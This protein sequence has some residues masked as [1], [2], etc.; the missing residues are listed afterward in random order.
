MHFYA[1]TH[2]FLKFFKNMQHEFLYSDCLYY[3]FLIRSFIRNMRT[4]KVPSPD[5]GVLNLS[6]Q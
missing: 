1:N 3:K 2:T 4:H 5:H 6:L